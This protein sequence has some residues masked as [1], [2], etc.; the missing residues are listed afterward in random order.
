MKTFPRTR[1]FVPI[2]TAILVI[3]II[4]ACAPF[5]DIGHGQFGLVIKSP[6][7]VLSQKALEN[8]LAIVQ[9]HPGVSYHFELVL[10]DGTR[11]PPYDH[12]P[13]VAIHTDKIFV[14]ELAQSLSKDGLTPI[15][16]A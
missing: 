15:G 3:F 9:K 4:Q 13:K 16:A 10:D 5:I 7:R 14:T 12:E 2:A 1:A 8:A 6:V 11:L